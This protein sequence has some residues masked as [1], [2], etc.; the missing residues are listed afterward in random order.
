MNK[1]DL[2]FV[3]WLNSKVSQDDLI[4][5]SRILSKDSPLRASLKMAINKNKGGSR[6]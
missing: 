5:A 1:Q 6:Q 3:K 4:S 2:A